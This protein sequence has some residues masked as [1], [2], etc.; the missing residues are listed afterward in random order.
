ME[1]GWARASGGRA[2]VAAI[3]VLSA[4]VALMLASAGAARADGAPVPAV[5]ITLYSA[6]VSGNVGEAEAG[7]TVTATLERGTSSF[8]LSLVDVASGTTVT[9]ANGGW[10]LSMAPVSPAAVGTQGFDPNGDWL[11]VQYASPAGQSVEVPSDS[12]YAS[13]EGGSPVPTEMSF[14]GDLS[15]VSADGSTVV[16][17]AGVDCGSLSFVIE[18]TA[19]PSSSDSDG[20]CVY[21]PVTPLTDED[22]VQATWTAS[23]TFADAGFPTGGPPAPSVVTTLSDVG[24]VGATGAP[25]CQGDLVTGQ[26]SCGPLSAGT[27]TVSRD[28]R[29][30]LT[31]TLKDAIGTATF[32]ALRPGDAIALQQDGAGRTL[33]TLHLTTLVGYGAG[34]GETIVCEPGEVFGFIPDSYFPCPASGRLSYGP[35]GGAYFYI[36]GPDDD[37]SGGS[38]AATPPVLSN[39]TPSDGAKVDAGD[40]AISTELSGGASPAG[41]SD[42]PDTSLPPARVVADVRSV[43]LRVVRQGGTSAVYEHDMTPTLGRSAVSERATVKGLTTGSYTAEFVV[44]DDNGDLVGYSASFTVQ[45]PPA[46]SNQEASTAE[47]KCVRRPA[48]AKPVSLHCAALVRAH[49][50]EHA[51]VKLTRREKLYATGAARLLHGTRNIKLRSLRPVVHGRYLLTLVVTRGRTKAIRRF[52]RTL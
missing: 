12:T 42:W 31:L 26:V 50:A 35:Y 17:P 10:S 48:N 14:V 38:T 43:S 11:H 22:H 25:T 18:G 16:G 45:Q 47:L 46:G 40:V 5:T 15:S 21:K 9:D 52:K 24:V 13:S 8:P 32:P 28:G 1:V 19:H 7:V 29:A 6:A 4:S 37:L 2:L 44:A 20:D 34:G 36:P 27:F 33:T 39:F 41:G 51:T 49:G 30:P 23:N 3:A